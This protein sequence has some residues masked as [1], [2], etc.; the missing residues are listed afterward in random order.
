MERGYIEK[1]SPFRRH[2]VIR[3]ENGTD[4]LVS[5]EAWESAEPFE[6]DERYGVEFDLIDGEKGP[7]AINIR[8]KGWSDEQVAKRREAATRWK[9][10]QEKLSAGKSNRKFRVVVDVNVLVSGA[11]GLRHFLRR[12]YGPG[13][14]AELEYAEDASKETLLLE[15]S[16]YLEFIVTRELLDE[17]ERVRAYPKF[18]SQLIG[19]DSAGPYIDVKLHSATLYTAEREITICRDPKDNYLLAAADVSDADYLITQDADL[20]ALGNFGRTKIVTAASFFDRHIDIEGAFGW[21][22]IYERRQ[23]NWVRRVD[24]MYIELAALLDE[25][26]DALV[27]M[28]PTFKGD[29]DYTGQ[30]PSLLK[31]ADTE[32]EAGGV[33]WSQSRRLSSPDPAAQARVTLTIGAYVWRE[34]D[35]ADIAA[36]LKVEHSHDRLADVRGMWTERYTVP[37]GSAQQAQTFDPIRL[38][39]HTAF[40]DVLRWIA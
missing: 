12:K 25:A 4:V 15:R 33:T 19:S 24:E 8:P 20:L 11:M 39:F 16:G 10:L 32:P 17:W 29:R 35:P 31:S 7:A 14:S 28:L 21:R 38:G 36:E 2:G 1:W 23:R 6:L 9:A 22:R 5:R 34:D 13:G 40:E 27:K 30:W 37:I 18:G 26:Y 3:A